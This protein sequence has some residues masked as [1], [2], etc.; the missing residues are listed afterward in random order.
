ML[1]LSH[2]YTDGPVHKIS[3]IT[4]E[5]LPGFLWVILKIT[6][7]T[8]FGIFSKNSSETE[9]LITHLLVWISDNWV[10]DS[11]LED[12]LEDLLC[13]CWVTSTLAFL[14]HGPFT[15]SSLAL[16]LGGAFTHAKSSSDANKYFST[17]LSG[18]TLLGIEWRLSCNIVTQV[19]SVITETQTNTHL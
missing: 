8:H 15:T 18:L 11:W 10:L 17:W 7:I 4:G 2:H 9:L 19:T 14:V 6:L 12:L 5:N 16:L 1:C 3:T 13:P